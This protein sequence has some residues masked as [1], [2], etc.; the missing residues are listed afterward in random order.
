MLAPG[1]CTIT[2]D[3]AGNA[4][5]SAAPQG[6]Q[7]F[8][9]QPIS[10]TVTFGAQS[11]KTFSANGTFGISPSAFA[12]SGLPIAYSSQTSNVCTVSGAIISMVTSGTCTIRAMQAG[13][14]ITASASADQSIAINP[15]LTIRKLA[16]MPWG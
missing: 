12:S 7:S 9:V 11:A 15:R 3:Q 8:N 16:C 2:A 6:L 1:N 5:Y 10:Q 13:D 4:T 14:G